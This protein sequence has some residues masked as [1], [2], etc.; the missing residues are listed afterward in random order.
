MTSILP[1]S[2]LMEDRSPDRFRIRRAPD[3]RASFVTEVSVYWF[4]RPVR[5]RTDVRTGGEGAGVR[6][7][8]EGA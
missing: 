5:T 3:E 1:A 4:R 7:A 8:R 6:V 2:V